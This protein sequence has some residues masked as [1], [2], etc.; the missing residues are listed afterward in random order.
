M[1]AVVILLCTLLTG[2]V[3]QIDPESEAR[4]LESRA[5]SETPSE[6]S[7]TE[8]ASEPQVQ[9]QIASFEELQ[10]L[11]A[12]QAGWI[13]VV[14]YWSTS[15]PPCL[16]EFPNLVEL[17]EQYSAEQVVCISASLDYE[18]LP[19]RPVETCRDTALEFLRK[20]NAARI[21]NLILSEDSLTVQDDLLQVPSIPIVD[22]YAVDGTLKRRFSDADGIP[23]GYE[24]DINPLIESLVAELK[25]EN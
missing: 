19:K 17:S 2:C 20:H 21:Q 11:I 16:K 1:R 10:Q 12:K 5:Q 7:Q 6:D 14:D 22:V 4:T 13:V 24:Q 8:S 25:T 15:C 3:A 23:F 9:L 18:G